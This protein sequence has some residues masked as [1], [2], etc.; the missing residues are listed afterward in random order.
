[1]LLK[2]KKKQI[3]EGRKQA[4]LSRLKQLKELATLYDNEYKYYILTYENYHNKLGEIA[5]E[6]TKLEKE[7]QE[8]D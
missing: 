2:K 8:Y 3:S 6:L 1:M 7:L 5:M 4:V